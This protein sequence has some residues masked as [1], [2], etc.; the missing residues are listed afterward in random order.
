MCGR[1]QATRTNYA[2]KYNAR[3]ELLRI[4]QRRVSLVPSLDN[5]LVLRA[6][7]HKKQRCLEVTKKRGDKI[8]SAMKR[9]ASSY[10]L[11]KKS[12]DHSERVTGVRLAH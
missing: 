8:E 5:L 4:L 2:V 1:P 12:S 7:T 11:H 9:R 3:Q 10:R 6:E